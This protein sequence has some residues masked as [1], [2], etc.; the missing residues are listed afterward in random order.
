MK[1]Y[2]RKDISWAFGKTEGD[3]FIE[4]N[5]IQIELHNSAQSFDNYQRYGYKDTEKAYII[6]FNCFTIK[7]LKVKVP[8]YFEDY[9][10]VP[11]NDC[12]NLSLILFISVTF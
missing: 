11:L 1:R 9:W 3:I 4:S 5:S 10:L 12:L 7:C 6:I 8:F 2:F